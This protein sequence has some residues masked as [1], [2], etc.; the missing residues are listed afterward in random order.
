MNLGGLEA[1]DGGNLL[2]SGKHYVI[3]VD[4]KSVRE[5]RIRAAFRK[6]WLDFLILD[7]LDT[8]CECA[9]N[10]KHSLSRK[11]EKRRKGVRESYVNTRG[12]HFA[13]E[14]MYTNDVIKKNYSSIL[15]K[16]NVFYFFLFLPSGLSFPGCARIDTRALSKSS[17]PLSLLYYKRTNI[18]YLSRENP[19]YTSDEKRI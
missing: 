18:L 13:A 1:S 6:F 8:Q 19:E 11:K 10:N 7:C 4:A 15:P 12:R 14:N 9:H 5:W 17:K 2:S 3:I 16:R